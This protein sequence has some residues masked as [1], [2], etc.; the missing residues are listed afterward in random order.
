M[1]ILLAAAATLLIGVGYSFAVICQQ[2]DKFWDWL[3]T[4]VGSG[5]SFFLAVL[6]G[7]YLFRLQNAA[8]ERSEREA[9]RELLCAE[10]S[11]LIRILSDTSKMELTTQSG[12]T[13]SVLVAF[14]QPLVIEKS[15]VS[16]LFSR[17][18]SE[19]LLHIA[20]KIRMFSFKTE[21]MMSVIQARAEEQFIIHA[22]DNVEQT[23]VGTIEG[24]RHVARQLGISINEHYPD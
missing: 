21:H 18:E 11:D 19:N 9:L 10:F 23:R 2:P 4:L 5:L 7:I 14:V 16:G 3:N 15:A 6:G 24:I 8:T 12:L 20:R 22:A 1:H 17:Q 13:K